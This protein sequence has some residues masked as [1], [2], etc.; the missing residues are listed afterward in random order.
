MPTIPTN[1]MTPAQAVELLRLLLSKKSKTFSLDEIT[2]EE[3][4]VENKVQDAEYFD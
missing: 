1:I 3:V 4:K 2:D